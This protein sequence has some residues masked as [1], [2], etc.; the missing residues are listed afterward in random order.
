MMRWLPFSS[1]QIIKKIPSNCTQI[2]SVKEYMFQDLQVVIY[3]NNMRNA[4]R[5]D[6][7]WIVPCSKG[8]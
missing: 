1:A 3:T 6:K 7:D 4:C 8:S 2:I 5:G